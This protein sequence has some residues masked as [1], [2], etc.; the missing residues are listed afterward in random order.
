MRGS[1][2]LGLI[3]GVLY[4]EGCGFLCRVGCGVWVDG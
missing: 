1:E 3:S 2:T 4:F